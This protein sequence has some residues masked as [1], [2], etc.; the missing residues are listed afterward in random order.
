MYITSRTHGAG[1]RPGNT[2]TTTAT[3]RPHRMPTSACTIPGKAEGGIGRP[4]PKEKGRGG[5]KRK[6]HSH[7][8]AHPCHKRRPSPPARRRRGRDPLKGHRRTTKPKLATPN[9]EQRPY[10][11]R[12]TPNKPTHNTLGRNEKKQK[13][14]EG[15]ARTRWEGGTDTTGPRTRTASGRHRR[16]TTRHAAAPPP[17]KKQTPKGRG[18]GQTPP[19][20]T[21]AQPHATGG[22]PGRTGCKRG[23]R[24]NTHTP[25]RRLLW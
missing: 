13:T 5:G 21:P 8:T 10:G 3:Q 15:A 4:P 2:Q 14:L 18:G 9:R 16:A 12:D 19:T 17:K 6:A 22:P 23:T 24:T 25:P 11:R 7:E 1:A 20:T